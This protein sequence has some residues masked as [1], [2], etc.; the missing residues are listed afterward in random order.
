MVSPYANQATVTDGIETASDAITTLK[1]S[2]IGTV[3]SWLLFTFALVF[4]LIYIIQSVDNPLFGVPVVDAASYVKWAARIV[5]GIWLWDQVDNYLIIYP[6]FLAIQ[7]IIPGPDPWVNKILQCLMGSATVVLMA[8]VVA[9]AW[10]RRLGLI[11]G[12]LL[13]TYW[14]LVVFEAE[15]FSE[16]FSIFFLSLTLWLLVHH[17]SKSCALIGAGFTFAL[18]AGA[19]AN[20][21]LALPCISLW[22]IWVNR[23]QWQV[24][25]KSILLFACGTAIIIG[26]IVARN[27]YLVGRPMLRAQATWSLY[28]GLAPEFD[29]L[30]PPAGILFDK[31]MNMPK[32]S[33]AYSELEVEYYWGRKLLDVLRNDPGGVALNFLRRV[34]I[35]MNA[36][37]WSQ[38]FDVSAYRSYS[39][40]LSLPWP[41]FWLIGPLGFLGLGL[42]RKPSSIQ[43]LLLI[44]TIAVIISIIPF[45]VSDR[46]RLPPAVLLT[47]FTALSLGYFSAWLR[48]RNFRKLFKWLTILAFLCLICWPDWQNLNQRK[49]AR[50][51]FFIRKHYEEIGRLSDAAAGCEKSMV[52]YHWDAD[53]AYRMAKVLVKLHE[54]ERAVAYLNEALQREP[55]FPEA[56]AQLAR[57]EL[58]NGNLPAAQKH[59]AACLELDPIN[60][61]GLILLA[62]LQRRRGNTRQEISYYV[63]AI[64]EAGS[65]TAAMLLAHRFIEMG[66]HRDAVNLYD[67]VMRSRQPNKES[68][69]V[70]A[71]LAGITAAR[72][73]DHKPGQNVYLQYI[74]D[75]F[76]EFKFF[77]LQARYLNGTLSEA[78]FRLQMGD[79][80]E[81]KMST[82]YLVGLNH[83]LHANRAAAAA[84]FER[85]LQIDLG[86]KPRSR[87]TPQKWAREDLARLNDSELQNIE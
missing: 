33:G 65:H 79:A 49:W 67:Q 56:L 82:E 16:T 39:G 61:D 26:P 18:A 70:A 57:H 81:Q 73:L 19:R 62:E 23:R 52:D 5:D 71:M 69:V 6:I 31:Y 11:C 64:N 80:P 66:N 53:S 50:H 47:I 30:H 72:F 59:L 84:A 58:R 51:D 41:G 35:F 37:E 36:R 77:S 63:K 43:L 42:C 1:Y 86:K 48:S 13:A 27:H 76:D 34:L 8:Q 54:Y 9:R 55:D 7:Q 38:E 74:I 22:L 60:A 85:C 78:A 28:S 24:S 15:K 2:S 10:N 20:L 87:Y 29:G 14:M 21:F 75:E 46:Y 83:W 12:Y 32:T 3:S 40:F 44:V 25:A 4:R 68:R 45:K 17:I